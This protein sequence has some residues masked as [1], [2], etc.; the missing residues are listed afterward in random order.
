[1][2]SSGQNWNHISPTG[3]LSFPEIFGENSGISSLYLPEMGWPEMGWDEPPG[4]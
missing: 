1:M 2:E 4:P 3:N